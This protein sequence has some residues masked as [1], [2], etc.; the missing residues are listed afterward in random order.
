MMMMI[1][2]HSYSDPL[3]ILLAIVDCNRASP[4][5]LLRRIF[6]VRLPLK[7]DHHILIVDISSR[8]SDVFAQEKPMTNKNIDKRRMAFL[9]EHSKKSKIEK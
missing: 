7:S 8:R 3:D 5:I 2:V 1:V 6:V 4:K 9:V